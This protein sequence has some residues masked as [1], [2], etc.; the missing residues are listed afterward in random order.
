MPCLD[1]LKNLWIAVFPRILRHQIWLSQTLLLQRIQVHRW[2]A[3]Y[4]IYLGPLCA[5]TLGHLQWHHSRDEREYLMYPLTS[6]VAEFGGILG[7]FLGVSFMT[8][9][10]GVQKVGLLVRDRKIGWS[11]AV[12]TTLGW[13]SVAV[14]TKLGWRS[15]PVVTKMG[16][17]SDKKKSQICN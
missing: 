16:W 8:I 2:Q 11:V 3:S 15:V 9:W 10:D 14:E 12:A 7:L 5:L 1:S 17:K 13:Q 6:L 4:Q